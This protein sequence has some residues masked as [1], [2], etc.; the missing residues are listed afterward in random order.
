M[1]LVIEPET[2]L[3]SGDPT[4]LNGSG[5]LIVTLLFGRNDD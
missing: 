1:K 5:Q 2:A 3:A 4:A